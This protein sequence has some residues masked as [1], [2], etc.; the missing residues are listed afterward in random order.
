MLESHLKKVIQDASERNKK[1]KITICQDGIDGC[2]ILVH[3]LSENP[4]CRFQLEAGIADR[5]MDAAAHSRW[6]SDSDRDVL[7]TMPDTFN[8]TMFIQ[9]MSGYIESAE[10]VE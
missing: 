9:L 1:F 10:A 4:N 6:K 8:A 2:G 5:I 7:I 3:L